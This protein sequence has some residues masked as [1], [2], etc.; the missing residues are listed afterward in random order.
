MVE[1]SAFSTKIKA[2]VASGSLKMPV[3]CSAP[4]PDD[5]TCG[6]IIANRPTSAPPSIGRMLGRTR[7]L[8][9]RTSQAATP[10]ISNMPKPAASRP[11]PPAM[12][13]SCT[14]RFDTVPVSMPSRSGAK[15]CAVR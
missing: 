5:I 9:N 2:M 12:T 15:A 8:V 7:A 6:E 4:W 13:T 11:R 1:A 3:R 14:A 10:R